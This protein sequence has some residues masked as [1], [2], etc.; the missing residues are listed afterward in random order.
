MLKAPREHPVPVLA[1]SGEPKEMEMGLDLS[2]PAGLV[3]SGTHGGCG[4]E[5][6]LLLALSA[7][8]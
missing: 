1:F 7:A 8:F 2:C 5:L 6:C 3:L 4:V